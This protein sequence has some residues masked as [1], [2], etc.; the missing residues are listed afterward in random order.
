MEI[1]GDNSINTDSF[2]ESGDIG[3]GDGDSG[4]G[5]SVLDKQVNFIILN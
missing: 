3:S 4:Q 5:L 2:Q 1:N